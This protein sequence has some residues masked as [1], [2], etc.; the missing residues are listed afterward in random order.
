MAFPREF[1]FANAEADRDLALSGLTD[2]QGLVRA[3]CQALLVRTA[4][5]RVLVDAGYGDLPRRF[6][7]EGHQLIENLQAE[8]VA[9]EDVDLVIMSHA[10]PDH[11]G[12]LIHDGRPV[13]TRARHLVCRTEWE[14]WTGGEPAEPGLPAQLADLAKEV[15]VPLADAGMLEL[16]EPGPTPIG[17]L[18]LLPAPGHT[19]GHLALEISSADKAAIFLADVIP[20]PLHAEH[21]DWL[22]AVELGGAE[23]VEKTR[24]ELLG[25]ATR[26]G[27]TLAGSHLLRPVTVEEAGAGFRLVETIGNFSAP[28]RGSES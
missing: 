3:P 4:D 16:I 28:G 21:P 12:G 15:L 13:F 8:G 10:H 11:A 9:P 7:G 23:A 20:H 1:L 14:F 25:R 26:E 19:P 6:E 18:R 17:G 22:L 2:D 24:R 5:K 27:C